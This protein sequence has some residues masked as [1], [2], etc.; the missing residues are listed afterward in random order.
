MPA[1]HG[2]FHR[3]VKDILDDNCTLAR[4]EDQWGKWWANLSRENDAL[5]RRLNEVERQAAE[6]GV[7][8]DDEELVNH[9]AELQ[10]IAVAT[11]HARYGLDQFR[12]SMV[13]AKWDINEYR[14]AGRSDTDI[15]NALV[16]LIDTANDKAK[17]FGD[18]KK[19]REIVARR[20]DEWRQIVVEKIDRDYVLFEEG[21]A[22]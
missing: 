10:A 17:G 21:G 1:P 15:L 18:L 7:P 2:G 4:L 22:S 14:K 3:S 6:R 19:A 20:R 16:K 13:E 11:E 9:S 12:V 5:W 8:L